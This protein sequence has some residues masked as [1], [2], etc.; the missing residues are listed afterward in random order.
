MTKIVDTG[1]AVVGTDENKAHLTFGADIA[2]SENDVGAGRSGFVKFTLDLAIYD[3]DLAFD[4]LVGRYSHVFEPSVFAETVGVDMPVDVDSRHM[5]FLE[6]GIESNVELF[7]IF[8]LRK[9]GHRVGHPKHTRKINL[10][11]TRDGFWYFPI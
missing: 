7:G 5:A 11:V 10:S 9:D 3:E 8:T 1:I 4:D 6:L 2:F